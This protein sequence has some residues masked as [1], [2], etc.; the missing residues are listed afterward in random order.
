[1]EIP[2]LNPHRDPSPPWTF[3]SSPKPKTGSRSPLNRFSPDRRSRGRRLPPCQFLTRSSQIIS[4]GNVSAPVLTPAPSPEY[5]VGA[6]LS[7]HRL[8]S[9][10]GPT[11]PDR[12]FST[13]NPFTN[14]SRATLDRPSLD[15]YSQGWS[16]GRTECGPG[17]PLTWV[18]LLSPGPDTK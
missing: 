9:G 5:V 15:T 10:T 4:L 14:V 12:L 7:S 2:L 3:R 18:R 6:L 1:M 8:E 17:V 11:P 13:R 16:K